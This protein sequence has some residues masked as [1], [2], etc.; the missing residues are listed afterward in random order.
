MLEQ[1]L[2]TSADVIYFLQTQL[3]FLAPIMRFFTF[4]GNEDFY[5]IVMPVF[6]WIIDYNMGVQLGIIMLLSGGFNTIFKFSLQQPRPYWT[7]PSIANLDAPHNSFG[8]PSGHSQNAVSLFG[9]LATWVKQKWLR[10]ILVFVILMVAFS[11]LFLG[12]HSLQDIALGLTVGSLIVVITVKFGSSIAGFFEKQTALTRIILGLVVSLAVLSTAAGIAYSQRDT[13]VIPEEWKDNAT[14]A[15]HKEELQPYDIDGI[16]TTCGALF[17]VIAGSIWVNETGGFNANQGVFWKRISRFF[18]GLIGVLVFWKILGDI[19]PRSGDFLSH[20]LR[21]FR[22]SLV[23]FWISGL[24][25]K[26]FHL[27]KIDK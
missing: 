6:L 4:L 27:I 10:I 22:Y 21:Y 8:L 14:L 23:G 9:M 12:V 7:D 20:G 11:R 24:A 15:G 17:G 19:F 13:F 18:V 5:L 26:L 1:L 2:S 3:A 25:P 16:I